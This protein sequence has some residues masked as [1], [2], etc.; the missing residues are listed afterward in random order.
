MT[1]FD[2]IEH[3]MTK[4]A[5]GLALLGGA[6]LIFATVVTCISIV[7]KLFR[8]GLDSLFGA[9]YVGDLMPWLRPILG[10]EELVTYGVGFALF[11][12]L[13]W[14]MIRKG[15]IKV[16]L[17]EPLF[18]RRMNRVLD[19]F[20]DILL[21]VIAYL[22]LTRQWFLVFKKARGSKEPL[23]ELLLGGNFAEAADRIRSSQ[24][25]QI[26]GLPLWPTY[27]VAEFCI[28][29]FF[30]VA[31]FCVFRSARALVVPQRAGV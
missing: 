29:V 15:H 30:V 17:F 14:V 16:D 25:S 31:L 11:A 21:A 7:L 27:M 6:G 5:A 8:R 2:R 12:A 4:L 28:L 9:Q 26:L 23:G 19:L 13:P 10:E 24:E 3:G 22:I 20:G 1:G 18:G